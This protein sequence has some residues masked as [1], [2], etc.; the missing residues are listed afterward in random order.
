MRTLHCLMLQ[1][2]RKT[3]SQ[4]IREVALS[5]SEA[6]RSANEE[7]AAM[8]RREAGLRV[9]GASFAGSMWEECL[10]L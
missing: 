8:E 9:S 1:E 3:A 4:Q 10:P 7:K 6:V 2:L 5:Q